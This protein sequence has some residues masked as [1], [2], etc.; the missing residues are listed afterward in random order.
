[1]EAC[2]IVVRD[3]RHN[4]ADVAFKMSC[5]DGR[6]PTVRQSHE[7]VVLDYI[8]CLREI[9]P[10]ALQDEIHAVRQ[11][12]QSDRARTVVF[13]YEV[14]AESSVRERESR[15]AHDVL[16]A[17]IRRVRDYLVFRPALAVV[18]RADERD[19]AGSVIRGYRAGITAVR[20][21]DF[22]MNSGKETAFAVSPIC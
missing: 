8:I 15:R 17:E 5:R 7:A 18:E 10:A 16:H 12:C 6:D 14:D 9:A 19:V 13:L 11:D 21:E 22:S 20:E 1:M 4:L 2:A 3:E